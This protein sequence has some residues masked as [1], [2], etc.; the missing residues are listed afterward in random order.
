ML[1]QRVNYYHKPQLALTIIGQL[2]QK[3][4]YQH[5]LMFLWV[6]V[7]DQVHL[8]NMHQLTKMVRLI[9]MLK[10]AWN[11]TASMGSQTILRNSVNNHNWVGVLSTLRNELNDNWDLTLGID[12]RHYKGEHFRE[13][14][15]LLGGEYWNEEFRYA[16]DGVAGRDQIRTVDDNS[17]SLWYGRTPFENRIAYDNDGLVTYGGV[18]GQ[19]EYSKDNLSIL[20]LVVYLTHGIL[21]WIDLIMLMKK[22]KHLKLYLFLDIIKVGANYNIDENN[23]AFFNAGYYSRRH[24]SLI[25][26]SKIIKTFFLIMLLMK[27]LWLLKEDISLNL[28]E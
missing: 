1:N 16:V 23:N 24:H 17:T 8:V 26:C 11:D 21:V 25:S 9:G 6:K 27:R 13:V 14:R 10:N 19:A 18:F 22:I 20:K 4:D 15:D 3:P 12:G 2:I 28:K 5:Q 7:V